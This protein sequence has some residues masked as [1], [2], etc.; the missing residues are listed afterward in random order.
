MTPSV[1]TDISSWRKNGDGNGIRRSSVSTESMRHL[2]R[3]KTHEAG[4]MKTVDN[5]VWVQDSRGEG[6]GL[7][8]FWIVYW[9]D[10]LL[11]RFILG[12]STDTGVMG[13]HYTGGVWELRRAWY[14]AEGR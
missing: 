11:S 10:G 6:F 2:T 5:T 13:L 3:V 7:C 1:R 8:G 12:V 9:C 14:I 4:V